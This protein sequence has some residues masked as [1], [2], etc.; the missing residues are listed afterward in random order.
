MR[1]L[2]AILL[3]A[4]TGVA[5]ADPWP[6]TLTDQAAERG[7]RADLVLPMPCGGAMA[8]QKV[9]VPVDAADPLADRRLLLGQASDLASYSDGLRTAFLR[10][11][12]A[13]NKGE[14]HYYIARY[15]MIVGQ[16]R[17]LHG[18]CLDPNRRDR[19]AK[20]GLSWFDAVD[21]ARRYSE[22]LLNHAR[23]RL[24]SSDGQPGFVRLPTEEEWE[25]AARGGAR[26][27]AARFAEK[28]Y[29]DEGEMRDH[30]LYQAPGSGRGRL[31]AVGLRRPN[32]LGLYDIYGNAE[33]LVLGPFR[34]NAGGRLHGQAGGVVT[35]GGSV[36]STAEDLYSARRTEYPA[37]DRDGVPMRLDT[38]GVRLV[39]AA[40]VVTSD[41][42]LTRI[43]AAWQARNRGGIPGAAADPD[44]LLTDL[45]A[46][47]TDPR[48]KLG[49]SAVLVEL[50]RARD[51]AQTAR[52][53][54]ARSTLLS[55]AMFVGALR[56][57]A[58]AIEAKAA[59]IRMLV[60]LQRA[61]G[62]SEMLDRQVQA[63]L[64]EIGELR[65]QRT[66]YLLSYRA[67]LEALAGQADDYERDT[68]HDVLDEELE[69][70]RQV[71]LRANF[72]RFW[73]GLSR[74]AQKPDMGA[75][76]LLELALE[77]VG[78]ARARRGSS[79]CFLTLSGLS[80]GLGSEGCSHLFPAVWPA[81]CHAWSRISMRN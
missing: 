70:S 7:A 78:A 64:R 31:G 56:A 22:W 51:R 60:E 30:A 1:R 19:V 73:E 10:G 77:Q 28:V 9:T 23:D 24:P 57:N 61:G 42:A 58:R 76:A 55:G 63:H 26:V 38:F 52:L 40:P 79:L 32:P 59:N 4:V 50:R 15:E 35:R 2:A 11:A 17:A 54:S 68:T 45:I 18:D 66:T 46:A 21:A 75:R 49:L 14:S 34:L 81:L 12:F 71:E 62:R 20:G 53:Q 43:R 39:I 5:R 27:D 13:G 3:L 6:V 80:G 16:W 47:E 69:L 25:F 65:A 36:L 67:A 72:R 48:R 8:F 74:F 37:N 41:A 29:F 33:E 44:Q